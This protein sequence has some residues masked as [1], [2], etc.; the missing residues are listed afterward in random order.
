M[1]VI[2][3]YQTDP[4]H[5]RSSWVLIGV[6]TTEDKRDKI[7]RKYLRGLDDKPSRRTREE[8]FNQLYDMGQTQCLAEECGIEIY[9]DK[10]NTDELLD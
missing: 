7:V 1:E 9:T 6:A 3:I 10:I 2:L 5:G 8:A 4:W